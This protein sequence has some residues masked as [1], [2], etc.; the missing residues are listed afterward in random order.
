MPIG[1]RIGSW[2]RAEDFDPEHAPGVSSRRKA[3][4]DLQKQMQ[5]QILQGGRHMRGLGG[6][7]GAGGMSAA[8][9]RYGQSAQRATDYMG[10]DWEKDLA[11][12]FQRAR[13]RQAYERKMR[14]AT[15]GQIGADVLNE[16]PGF[17]LESLMP[18]AGEFMAGGG[19]IQDLWDVARVQPGASEAPP[20][21]LTM[22]D[23]TRYYEPYNP[24]WGQ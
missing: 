5:A 17:A 7:L 24:S 18:G 19:S 10:V 9:G 14:Q 21:E 13:A 12:A 16:L 22:D 1:K 15:T 23:I 3:Y 8:S 4:A 20:M 6:Q 11:D 2:W